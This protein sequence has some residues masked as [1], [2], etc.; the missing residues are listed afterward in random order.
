[1]PSSVS[2][3]SFQ[4]NPA[5]VPSLKTLFN[6]AGYDNIAQSF[7]D[8][9]EESGDLTNLF[10]N[11]GE[12]ATTEFRKK[13]PDL[14]NVSFVLHKDGDEIL[15]KVMEKMQYNMDER[16]D[17]FKHFVSIL[18]AL[19]SQVELKQIDNAIILID[20]PD[21]SLYPNAAKAL[22]DELLKLSNNNIVIYATHSPFMID[23]DTCSRHIIVS[24]TQEITHLTN[25]SEEEESYQKDSVLLNA[26]GT[27]RFEYIKEVNIIFEGWSDYHFFHT[28]LQTTKKEYKHLKPFFDKIATT[29]SHGVSAIKHITPILLLADKDVFIL[30]DADSAAKTAQKTY[31]QENGYKK[32]QWFTFSDLG[33]FDKETIEDFVSDESLFAD[34]L[35]KMNRSNIDLN[36]RGN[37]GIMAFL[38]ER[39]SKDE[40][41]L[42]KENVA[43][44]ITW[45]QIDPSYYE[46]LEELKNRIEN[47]TEDD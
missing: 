24:K 35:N 45:K 22:R 6:L 32:Q 18:L 42:F 19:S 38:T 25:V 7:V 43:R 33:F 31:Q 40:R 28:A 17:G 11:V 3:S 5:T 8:A 2:L 34:I 36:K 27:S 14:K 15:I 41:L 1:M 9:R 47:A 12:K 21:R 4:N 37:K 23:N 46:L 10:Q 20:E 16:S 29:F 39:L 26:M 30:S 13:W 44:Q